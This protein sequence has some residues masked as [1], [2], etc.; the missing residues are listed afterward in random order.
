MYDVQVFV[1]FDS[2]EAEACEVCA[3]SIWLNNKNLK[4]LFIKQESLRNDGIYTRQRD[5]RASTEFSLTRFLTP[6]L[7]TSKYAIFCDGDFVFTGDVA[8]V[9]DEIDKDAVVS[10]VQHDYVPK[11]QV[12]MNGKTQY[13]YPKKNWSSFMVFNVEKAKKIL[14]P[15]LVNTADP[16]YLHQFKWA[17]PASLDKKWNH[18]VGEYKKDSPTIG[19][20]YTNGG[21]WHDIKTELD[22]IWLN[23]RHILNNKPTE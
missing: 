3:H 9:L 4:P 5:E 15:E 11:Q 14:T 23:Y 17:E 13:Q 10:C 18:L 1:G 21:P 6:F 12:K 22:S 20:H 8:K 19:I 2:N 16:S 7:S